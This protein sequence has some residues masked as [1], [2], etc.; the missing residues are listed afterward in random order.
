GFAPDSKGTCYIG[1]AGYMVVATQI[2][3]FEGDTYGIEDGY[4]VINGSITVDGVTYEF[5]EDG[6]LIAQDDVMS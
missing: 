6:K 2:V 4:M 1:D 5:G 3:E